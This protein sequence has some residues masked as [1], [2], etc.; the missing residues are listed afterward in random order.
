M[1]G[2][3]ELCSPFRYSYPDGCINSVVLNTKG[4]KRETNGSHSNGN[5]TF[6]KYQDAHNATLNSTEDDI[7]ID[8]RNLT[9][10]LCIYRCQRSSYSIL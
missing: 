4:E 1:I 10:P 6:E 5:S 3:G 9:R 2:L 8:I 7:N